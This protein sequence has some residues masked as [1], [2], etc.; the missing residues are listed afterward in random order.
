M[1]NPEKPSRPSEPSN[2]NVGA[3][4]GPDDILDGVAQSAD[5]VHKP[6]TCRPN[7]GAGSDSMDDLDGFAGRTTD[8]EEEGVL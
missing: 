7:I 1:A 3:V 6:S 2:V 4:C 5:A 8:D